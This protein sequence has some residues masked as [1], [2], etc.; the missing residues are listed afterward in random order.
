MG[1]V[2]LLEKYLGYVEKEPK[3]KPTKKQIERRQLENR[4]RI[5]EDFANQCGSSHFSEWG[6]EVEF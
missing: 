3:K 1:D 6:D 2:N 4:R 5:S